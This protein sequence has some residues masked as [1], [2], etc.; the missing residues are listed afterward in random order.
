MQ[1]CAGRVPSLQHL[2]VGGGDGYLQ[3]PLHLGLRAVGVGVSFSSTPSQTAKLGVHD[4]HTHA[5]TCTHAHTRTYTHIHTRTHTHT[6]SKT[7]TQKKGQEVQTNRT[8]QT[9]WAR[10]E[11][12]VPC[13]SCWQDEDA[14]DSEGV[15]MILSPNDPFQNTSEEMWRRA[16]EQMR[17]GAA[18][19][20]LPSSARCKGHGHLLC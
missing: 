2:R 13:G 6:L 18:V 12:G 7:T 3:R 4:A 5:H 16:A 8:P 20:S 1:F 10:K 15:C 14:W 11:K 17:R 9:Q 19:A